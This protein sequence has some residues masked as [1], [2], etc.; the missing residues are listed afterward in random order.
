MISIPIHTG[1]NQNP[2]DDSFDPFR[3]VSDNGEVSY[4]AGLPK[5]PRNFSRDVFISGM[6]ASKPDLLASQLEI[7]CRLQGTV[8][9]PQTGEMIGRIHH[10]YPGVKWGSGDKYTTYDACDSTALFLIAAEALHHVDS[11]RVSDFVK[12]RSSNLE[13]AVSYIFNHLDENELFLEE[14]PCGSSSF[15]IRV[16]YWKDSILPQSDGKVEPVYPVIYPQAHFIAA[17][18]LLSASR[19]LH[20][21]DLADASDKMFQA[22]IEEFIKPDSYSVYRD[23][24]EELH[25]A[26]SD[27]L[28]SLAYIP[29]TYTDLLPFDAIRDRSESLSTPFGYICT[30]REIAPYLIDKY[31]SD[32]VWIFEQAMIHYAATKYRLAEQS[33][34]AA[35]VARYIDEGQELLGIRV[36]DNGDVTPVAEGNKRQL[37]SVAAGQYFAGHS[38][39]PDNYWL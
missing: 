25:Q 13:L 30:P 16:T 9:D 4:V 1:E 23:S 35:S 21:A 8:S 15:A 14:P 31:H 10:E 33:A 19:L 28:H 2:Q 27:E 20:D 39:L 36:E 7:S 26:S 37:W 38:Q 29:R 17:R 32:K 12:Q 6:L 3:Q 5:F 11:F 18:G 34:V 22:G 24:A